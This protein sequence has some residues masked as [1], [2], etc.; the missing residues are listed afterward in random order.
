MIFRPPPAL[1][2]INKVFQSAI[3]DAGQSRMGDR[4]KFIASAMSEGGKGF[5]SRVQAYGKNDRGE[6]LRFDPWFLEHLEAIGDFRIPHVLT[7]A[8]AQLGKAQPLDVKVLTP[9]GWKL[10]GEV[11]AGDLVVSIDTPPGDTFRVADS[12]SEVLQV[13]PQGVKGVYRVTLESGA[14]TECCDEHLWWVAVKDKKGVYHPQV[15][16]LKQLRAILEE[17]EIKVPLLADAQGLLYSEM[18]VTGDRIA[19]IGYV[20]EKE[21]Q[22][23]LIDHPSHLYVT[24]DYIVTH[25]TLSHTLLACDLL[26]FGRLNFGWIY[27]TDKSLVANQPTQFRPVVD[28]WEKSIAQAGYQFSK[29]G[30]RHMTTR[31][32]IGSVNG[33]F[34]AASTSAPARNASSGGAV[35]GASVVSFTADALFLEERSQYPPG[36]ADPLPRRLDASMLSTKPIRELGTPGGGAGIETGFDSVS[37]YFYPHYECPECNAIAPLDPKGCLLRPY[38]HPRKGQC[39]LSESGKPLEWFHHNS[40]DDTKTAFFGCSECGEE[41]SEETRF[42]ARFRCKK[43]GVL[44]RDFLDSLPPGTPKERYKIVLH[45]SPLLRRTEFN[46]AA[47]LIVSGLEAED[48]TDWQQQSLGHVSETSQNSISLE[49]IKIAIK[50]PRPQ[51]VPSVTLC[52]VDQGRGQYWVWIAEYIIT[53]PMWQKKPVEVVI[54]SSIRNVIFAG[55]IIKGAIAEKLSEYGVSFGLID[56]EPERTEAGEIQRTT[57]LQMADQKP[58]QRDAIIKGSVKDGG[59]SIPCWF[60]RNEKFLRQVLSSFLCLAEDGFPLMRLPET[61][62]RWLLNQ[63]ELSPVRHLMTPSYDPSTGKWAKKPGGKSIDDL[64]Y[65]CMFCESAFYMWLTRGDIGGIGEHSTVAT[66]TLAMVSRRKKKN[67]R[68]RRR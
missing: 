22:C 2:K 16:E 49:T 13:F 58:G 31:Y 66:G 19:S 64:Y 52:G 34:A 6:P 25:N 5:L 8:A 37:H 50:A 60:I 44:L 32:Q 4:E 18:A 57:C 27:A 68:R 24:D 40:Q 51:R 65:A 10:M 1:F 43:T 29:R 26:T 62:T 9:T 67:Q 46:L 36:A 48:A 42:A 21:C 59:A 53:D 33:I 12:P 55:P 30:D 35:A 63:G 14:T 39:F 17:F 11:Q 28:N 41:L 15:L 20:G 45:F 3:G 54:E 38:T 56:N 23:I 61:W 7:V 47:D